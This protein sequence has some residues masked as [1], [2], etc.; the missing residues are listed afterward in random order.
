MSLSPAATRFTRNTEVTVFAVPGE[1]PPLLSE[2]DAVD[3]I[4]ESYG[5]GADTIVIPVARLHPDFLRL[6][7]RAAGLFLQKFANYGMRVAI[8]G[9][10]GRWT[11]ESSALR[12]F[13]RE[14]NAHGRV[15]FVEDAAELERRLG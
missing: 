15:L 5:S 6:R 4:G 1:G 10:I 8:V 9:D 2:Q 3:L 7:T 11:A 13:V 12:D 14:S